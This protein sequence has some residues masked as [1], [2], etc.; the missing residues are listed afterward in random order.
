MA[1]TERYDIY[2]AGQVQDGQEAQEVRIQF[3]ALFDADD[4]TLDR[5]FSGRPNIIKR[6]CDRA[7][8]QRYKNAME[9]A[10]AVPVI[11]AQ[12]NTVHTSKEKTAAEKI[13]ALAAAPDETGYRQAQQVSQLASQATKPSDSGIELSPP[14]TA[15]L[16]ESER[17]KPVNR[18]V[19]TS[20]LFID[21]TATRLAAESQPPVLSLDISHLTVAEAGTTIPNLLTAETHVSPNT[22]ALSLAALGTDYS[23]C[24]TPEPPPPTLDLSG[25]SVDAPGANLVEGQYRKKHTDEMPATSHL[26]LSD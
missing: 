4:T 13:A 14:G 16:R 24:A 23:D 19:D 6:G 15:V 21:T 10:G 3:R 9:R 25:L 7:T 22:D 12:Q 18:E 17:A 2:F 1:E 20:A 11:R 8:A 5:L 26:S